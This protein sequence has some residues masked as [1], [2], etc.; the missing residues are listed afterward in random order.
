MSLQALLRTTPDGKYM[1]AWVC[2]VYE[3]DHWNG[4]T[5]AVYSGNITK[6]SDGRWFMARC[7][8]ED[9]ST[10]GYDFVEVKTRVMDM[11]KSYVEAKRKLG[12]IE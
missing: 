10:C 12:E 9:I 2:Q 5:V 7:P 11:C 3:E 6:M 4:I 1:W 8:K